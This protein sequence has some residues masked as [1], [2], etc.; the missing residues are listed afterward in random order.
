MPQTKIKKGNQKTLRYNIILAR[1]QFLL[2]NPN[3]KAMGQK[4]LASPVAPPRS[5][6]VEAL[7]SIHGNIVGMRQIKRPRTTKAADRSFLM[8]GI[9]FKKRNLK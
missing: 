4:I 3:I 6:L 5:C 8:V 1:N 9:F 2:T 7:G